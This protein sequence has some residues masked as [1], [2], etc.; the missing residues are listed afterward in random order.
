[1]LVHPNFDPIALQ[2]GPVAIRTARR[3]SDGGQRFAAAVTGSGQ[4]VIHVAT[5]AW[6]G[7]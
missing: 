6:T 7:P 2:I 4:A 5:S 3:D 1:M